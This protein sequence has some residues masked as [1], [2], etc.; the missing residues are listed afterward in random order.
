ML[1]DGTDSL[2]GFYDNEP[3]MSRWLRR[4]HRRCAKV[5]YLIHVAHLRPPDERCA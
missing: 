3:E 2:R 1:H 4:L 5:S